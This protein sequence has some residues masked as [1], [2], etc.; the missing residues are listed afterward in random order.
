MKKIILLLSAFLIGFVVLAQRLEQVKKADPVVGIGKK[1]KN[2]LRNPLQMLQSILN[3]K[4]M[5][6]EF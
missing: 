2:K 6:M 5:I 4:F 1:N 3:Q